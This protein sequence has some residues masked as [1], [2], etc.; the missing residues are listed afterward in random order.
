MKAFVGI[1]FLTVVCAFPLESETE[2]RKINPEEVANE[3]EGDIVLQN[4]EISRSG[5]NG[6][7]DTSKRWP[8]NFYGQ[9]T[10]PYKI[11]GR[12]CKKT[13]EK[14]SSC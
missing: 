1:V 10:V 3:F 12:Y 7:V 2:Q 6:I 11:Q 4:S 14:S 13:A 5:R 8:K 9:V